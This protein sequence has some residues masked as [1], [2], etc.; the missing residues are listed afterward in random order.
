M[1]Q[2]EKNLSLN[3]RGVFS[4]RGIT[5]PRIWS[6][7]LAGCGLLA[8]SGEWG[9]Q[10]ADEE[11]TSSQNLFGEYSSTGGSSIGSNFSVYEESYGSIGP[12]VLNYQTAL[13]EQIVLVV[14]NS[15]TNWAAV[16]LQISNVRGGK[17]H[18]AVSALPVE[19]HYELLHNYEVP[20]SGGMVKFVVEYE[21]DAAGGELQEMPSFAF[22]PTLPFKRGLAPA[23]SRPVRTTLEIQPFGIDYY[24]VTIP[25]SSRKEPTEWG[26][27]ISPYQTGSWSSVGVVLSFDATPDKQYEIQFTDNGVDWFAALPRIQA[28]GN[29]IFWM[30]KGP[31]KT[32]SHP[33]LNVIPGGIPSPLRL[34]RVVELP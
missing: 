8:L 5:V 20:A 19:G 15:T 6:L 14:N 3:F 13:L 25:S 1:D 22:H 4:L 2:R 17:V 32:P 23:E 34:Y 24:S 12:I 31:P 29:Y 26:E 21:P 30:D 18:N 27:P 10:A 11:Q 9:L 7:L 28:V 16:T 33:M